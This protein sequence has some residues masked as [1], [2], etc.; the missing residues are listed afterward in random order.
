MAEVN[1][2]SFKFKVCDVAGN[3]ANYGNYSVPAVTASSTNRS[4]YCRDLYPTSY[5]ED[6][7]ILPQCSSSKKTMC[8]V[9][10]GVDN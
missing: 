8:Y 2:A 7:G 9:T 10:T 4:K 5:V 6:Y 3:C 1:K